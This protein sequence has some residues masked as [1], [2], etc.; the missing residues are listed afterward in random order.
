VLTVCNF[1]AGAQRVPLPDGA[2]TLALCSQSPAAEWTSAVA[3]G[4][5]GVFLDPDLAEQALR[6]QLRQ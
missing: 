2:W 5:T 6:S 3:P 1:A 4:A